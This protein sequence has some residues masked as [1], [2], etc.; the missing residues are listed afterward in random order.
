MYGVL[1]LSFD[2]CPCL[3]FG[4]IG[5]CAETDDSFGWS[6]SGF[7]LTA[8]VSPSRCVSLSLFY[9]YY[10]EK[11]AKE[12][13]S[14]VLDRLTLYSNRMPHFGV[15]VPTTKKFFMRG[16]SF[17]ALLDCGFLFRISVFLRYINWVF[18]NLTS[19]ELFPSKRSFFF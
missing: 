10:H 13:S 9:R 15:V 2:W 3:S 12:F 14:L 6:S 7:F 16:V 1:L 11:C 19:I 8:L 5:S 17:L 4:Y 18:L